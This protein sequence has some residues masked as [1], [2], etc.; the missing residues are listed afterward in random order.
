MVRPTKEGRAARVI[1][2][3][4]PCLVLKWCL[5]IVLQ[6]LTASTLINMFVCL[7]VCFPSRAALIV[8]LF[9]LLR[10]DETSTFLLLIIIVETFLKAVRVSVSLRRSG[11]PFF[12]PVRARRR[13]WLSVQHRSNIVFHIERFVFAR[14]TP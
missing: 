12:L 14:V 5:R 13:K 4:R 7:F 2:I 1:L 10:R 11:S 8:A 9:R 3:T 6:F